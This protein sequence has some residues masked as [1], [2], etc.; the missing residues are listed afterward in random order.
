[1]TASGLPDVDSFSAYGGELA[2]YAPI[3][4]ATTDEDASWRNLYA[5]NVA[6]MTQTAT[7]AWCAFVGH[8]TTPTDPASNVHGAV[9]G[10][11]LGVKPTMARSSTGVFT[12]TYPTSVNDE[13][14]ESHT[15]NLKRCWVN[16]EGATLYHVQA[17]VT[18]PNVITV[19]VFN[20]A[21]AANDGVGVTFSVF[22][23]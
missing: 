9:W 21:G 17:T 16:V 11:A 1:M 19:Y 5:M 14:N 10:N 6:A 2:N 12:I 20:S 23:I 4:D 8:G 3:E 18:S 7:R 15:V 13:L 22:A